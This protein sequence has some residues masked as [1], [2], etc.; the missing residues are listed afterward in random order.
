MPLSECS[1]YYNTHDY[2]VGS[3]LYNNVH[4]S[5]KT[6]LIHEQFNQNFMT[7]PQW[8]SNIPQN[9]ENP[10]QFIKKTPLSSF[11]TSSSE[12]SILQ[13]GCTEGIIRYNNCK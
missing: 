13:P 12:K 11:V 2:R 5:D 1:G 10:I 7:G 3:H 6:E 4:S 9:S 8:K